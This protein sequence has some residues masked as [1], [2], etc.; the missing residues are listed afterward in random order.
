[1][2]FNDIIIAGIIDGDE[3]NTKCYI[4]ND[5]CMCKIIYYA[6]NNNSISLPNERLTDIDAFL[7]FKV[8]SFIMVY[9]IMVKEGSDDTCGENRTVFDSHSPRRPC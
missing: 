6:P 7:F 2:K 1:M 8:K 3:Y 5:L 9:T 4:Q